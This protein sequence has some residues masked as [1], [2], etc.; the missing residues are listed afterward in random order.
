LNV[1]KAFQKKNFEMEGG[2]LLMAVLPIPGFHLFTLEFLYAVV[3][4]TLDSIKN[5]PFNRNKPFRF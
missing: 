1:K 5:L 3:S 2:I 4:S